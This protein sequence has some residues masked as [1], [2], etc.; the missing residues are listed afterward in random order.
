MRVQGK[1]HQTGQR[2]QIR[3]L[4]EV[5]S[6]VPHNRAEVEK[7]SQTITRSMV[8]PKVIEKTIEEVQGYRDQQHLKATIS[9][10]PQ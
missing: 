4:P 1:H 3:A 8:R 6:Q 9:I 5:H 10:F 7:I 2:I